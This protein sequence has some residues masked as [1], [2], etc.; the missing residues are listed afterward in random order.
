[1]NQI[2]CGI[3]GC[4][5]IAWRYDG[6]KW[7]GKISITHSSCFDRHQLTKLVAMYDP[8]KSILNEVQNNHPQSKSIRFTCDIKEFLKYDLDLI[9]IAS[10]T[11]FHENHILMCLNKK[12]PYL[13]IEKPITTNMK[14]YK[15]IKNKFENHKTKTRCSV[16]YFRRFLPQYNFLKSKV[17]ND[18]TIKS[19]EI[20]YSKQLNINGIH[21]IDL[22]NF[23]YPE[24][25]SPLIE[26]FSNYNEGNPSFGFNL[27]GVQVSIIGINV[28][29]HLIDIRLISNYGRYS[30]TKSGLNV[31]EEKT[32][33]NDNYYGFYH[34]SDPK[35]ISK[36]VISGVG[37]ED[38]IFLSLCN[39][40]NTNE[41]LLSTIDTSSFSQSLI[42]KVNL[43]Y[44]INL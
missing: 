14:S 34:L 9:S 19:I 15:K 16:N 23:F 43:H 40:I 18:E 8:N 1:M 20:Y 35:D 24:A 26:W 10:P 31:I 2:K 7:D 22:L 32:L 39:L 38:G 13:W 36:K 11:N 30:V 41:K 3:I 27:L 5:N 29:Y 33:S 21:L 25:K 44:N 28:P 4:G 42:E 12:I 37:V 6:G 17:I